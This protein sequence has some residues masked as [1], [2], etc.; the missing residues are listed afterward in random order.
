[1]STAVRSKRPATR[2]PPEQVP[3]RVTTLARR[4]LPR[5][6]RPPVAGALAAVLVGGA[7]LLATG[8][9]G[10]EYEGRVTLVAGPVPGSAQFGEVVALTLPALAEL[11]RSPSVLDTAATETG[12]TT[13][14][15]ADRISVELVPASGLAR[16]AVRGP[17]AETAGEAATVIARSVIE[18]DLLAPAG[19]L[20]LLDQ[21]PDVNRVAPDRGLGAGLALVAAAVAGVSAG[22]V[23]HLRRA[24][25]E[26]A[27]RAAA[28]GAVTVLTVDTPDLTDRL[29]L[30]C[31]AAGRPARTIAVVPALRARATAL[32]R[33]LPGSTPEGTAVVAVAPRGDRHQRA[34]AA[35]AG[36]L[37]AG[38]VLV[39]VVLA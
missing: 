6:G 31:G 12:L 15:L 28:G 10:T 5:L 4:L 14:E 1:M 22:A 16:L 26:A 17:S 24:P 21:R 37:P 19:T 11:A 35:T 18:A 30:L 23:A 9:G 8:L 36:V 20:R 27:A 3:G 2:R 25:D 32:A 33:S 7:V 39:A 38:T 13:G 29:A 34:L